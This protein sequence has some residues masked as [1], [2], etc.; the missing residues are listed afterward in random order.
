[1]VAEALAKVFK[2]PVY[3][4]M[5]LLVA[6]ATFA[7]AVWMPNLGLIVEVFADTNATLLQKISLPVAL[8]ASIRTNFSALSALY[9]IAIP[10]LFGVNVAMMLYF[11]KRRIVAAKQM[12]AGVGFLGMASGVL[13]IGCAACGSFILTSVLS[14]FGAAGALFLLPLHGGEF[15]ILGVVLLGLSIALV[16]KQIQ[17]PLVCKP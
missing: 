8:L 13:G 14:S 16:G 4:V 9:T 11:L 12:A 7:M 6:L 3:A 17:N 10:I 5:A 1:M 2:K 15:G